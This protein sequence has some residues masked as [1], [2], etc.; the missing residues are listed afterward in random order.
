MSFWKWLALFTFC[1]WIS[2]LFFS[3]AMKALPKSAEVVEQPKLLLCF[4]GVAYWRIGDYPQEFSIAPA[5]N[6]N[7]TLKYCEEKE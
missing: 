7:G 5:Y 4:D 6:R 1:G 3:V 2:I